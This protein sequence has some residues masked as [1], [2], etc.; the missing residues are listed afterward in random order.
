[1]RRIYYPQG[2]TSPILAYVSSNNVHVLST[3]WT[4]GIWIFIVNSEQLLKIAE[5]LPKK[6]L[7]ERQNESPTLRS[8]IA[9]AKKEPRALFE[10]YIVPALRPD[11]RVVTD[12]AYIPYDRQ[13]LVK[14]LLKRALAKPDE[15]DDNAMVSGKRYV[16]MWWD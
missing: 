13:E 15:Y 6:Q 16:W 14:F 12:G 11:E 9:V 5:M 4:A 10:I 7:N 1:M 8:F 2:F 3:A